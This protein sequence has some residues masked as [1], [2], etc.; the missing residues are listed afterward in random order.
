MCKAIKS[1]HIQN[2]SSESFQK[3]PFLILWDICILKQGLFR[4]FKASN[5]TSYAVCEPF[6]DLRRFLVVWKCLNRFP[7]SFSTSCMIRYAVELHGGLEYSFWN[8]FHSKSCF[9]HL[10]S[11]EEKCFIVLL[12]LIFLWFANESPVDEMEKL[13]SDSNFK[14]LLKLFSFTASI[15]HKACNFSSPVSGLSLVSEWSKLG[16][17]VYKFLYSTNFYTFTWPL[18]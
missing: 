13:I 15:S 8:T 3:H 5:T 16:F 11:R 4:R 6:L 9:F 17:P 10:N 1:I 2:S 14:L 18:H 7:D 12:L